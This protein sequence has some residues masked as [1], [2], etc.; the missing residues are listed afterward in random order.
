VFENHTASGGAFALSRSF[1]AFGDFSTYVGGAKVA[2]GDLDGTTDGNSRADIVV[3]SGAGLRGI[4]R[5]FDVSVNQK[6]YKATRQIYDPNRNFRNGLS[7]TLGDVNDDG[8]MDIITGAGP[9]GS[10]LVTV[11]DGNASAGSTPLS[12]FRA[13]PTSNDSSGI[14]VVAKDVDG[15]GKMQIY[16]ACASPS[17]SNYQVQRFRPLLG[18]LVDSILA[19]DANFSG[20]G[21]NLG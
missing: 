21:L 12:R 2:V 3:A 19:S 4:V 9:R 11:Y 18:Q 7:V 17:S 1:N 5:V 8:L 10:S 20:G 16:A 14:R 15:T 6:S 13:F